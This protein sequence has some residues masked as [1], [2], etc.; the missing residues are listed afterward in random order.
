MRRQTG[1]VALILDGDRPPPRTGPEILEL[2]DQTEF[3]EA[4]SLTSDYE[5]GRINYVP[6]ALSENAVLETITEGRLLFSF[7]IEGDPPNKEASYKQGTTYYAYVDFVEGPDFDEGRWIARIVNTD[8]DVVGLV[9]GVEVKQVVSFHVDDHERDSH[10][11]PVM[12]IHGLGVA[13]AA[14]IIGGGFK[15][16]TSTDKWVVTHGDWVPFGKGCSRT[17]YCT[18]APVVAIAR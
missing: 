16:P 18:P 3:V 5:G 15:P 13:E 11:K 4:A 10:S 9:P 7:T 8:G 6:A 2:A 14:R 12:H 1:V 17:F